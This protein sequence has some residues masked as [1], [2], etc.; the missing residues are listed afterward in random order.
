MKIFS[1]FFI[2]IKYYSFYL[3]EPDVV[4]CACEVAVIGACAAC[5]PDLFS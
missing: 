5:V 1:S 2:A 4:A 3:A